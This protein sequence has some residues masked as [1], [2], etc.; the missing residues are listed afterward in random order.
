MRLVGVAILAVSATGSAADAKIID[1]RI[2][3]TISPAFEG[4]AF[5]KAGAYERIDAVAEFAIDPKS[6]RGQK[7]VDLDKAPVDAMGMVRFSTEVTILR[8]VD[9]TKS[10]GVLL[11]EVPN[12]GRNLSFTLMNLSDTSSLP[13]TVEDLGDAY[14][15]KEG[16]TVVWSG[17]QTGIPEDLVNL[18]LPKL[19][20]VTGLSREEFVFD[21]AEPVSVAKL[22]Y[23]AA[24]FDPK[25]ATLSVRLRAEEPRAV[26][27]GLSFRYLSPTSIEITRPQGLDAGA[28]FEFT[29][30]AKDAVPAGL[31]FAATS[32][33]VSYLRGNPGHDAP[34]ILTGVKSTIGLGI[35]QSG[36]FLR[37]LIYQ[38][39]NS[40]EQGT[41]VFDGAMAHIAGSRKSFTNYRFAQAGRYSRQ[42]EDHDFPGDQFPFTYAE[43]TDPL[44]GR[45]GSILSACSTNDTCPKIMHT[46]TSTEFWQARASLISTSPTGEPLQMPENVRLYFIAGAPHFTSW[47]PQGEQASICRFPANPLSSAPVMRSLLAAMRSWVLDGK[48]PP[49]S[50]YPSVADETL[51]PLDELKL[52]VFGQ[53]AYTPVY[54]VLRV[55]DH[56]TLPPKDGPSYP[57]LVPQLDEDG[58]PIGGIKDP[59]VAA[60][61]GTY[62]GWNLRKDGFAGGDLCGLNGSYIPLPISGQ[63]AKGDSRK[64]VVDRYPDADAYLKALSAASDKLIAAGVMRAEDTDL[65]QERGR[66]MFPQQ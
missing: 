46:D 41:R 16:Y 33:L 18:S 34:A 53:D 47:T 42:H 66:A 40:D 11:Y 8:P 64:P 50:V 21:K 56:D 17:W 37:D 4:T 9:A 15:M 12:R 7:I 35:S 52:P 23:P 44:S 58:I 1:F 51:V 38:G 13:K 59:A 5:G 48:D 28:I 31:A 60:P 27:P 57:V 25:K 22:T 55:R 10:Q 30:P 20:D 61:L 3:E 49:A 29:Y 39:F 43:T 14:L 36:R 54:N 19:S 32:D 6:E 24:D 45:S 65:I 26:A 62:W 63:E 2:L